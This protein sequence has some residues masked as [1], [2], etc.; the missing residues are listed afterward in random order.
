[1]ALGANGVALFGMLSIGV[2]VW[3]L[4][5]LWRSACNSRSTQPLWSAV[6]RVICVINVIAFILFAAFA[7]AIKLGL[8]P[9]IPSELLPTPAGVGKS[10][11]TI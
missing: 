3:Q 10:Q 4:V 5:G 6:A 9:E 7:L 1:M 8:V 11:G 2:S